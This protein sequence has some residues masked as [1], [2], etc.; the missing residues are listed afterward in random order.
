MPT[1]YFVATDKERRI[2]KGKLEA[3]D[4]NDAFARLEAAGFSQIDLE[5]DNLKDH[6]RAPTKSVNPYSIISLVAGLIGLSLLPILKPD[7]AG[8]VAGLVF[9]VLLCVAFVSAF[10]GFFNRH[11]YR[12]LS[13]LSTVML[14][15]SSLIIG[16][17]V[18][19]MIAGAWTRL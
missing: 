1:F 9:L 10:V 3:A 4:K 6:E 2:A 11:S 13:W 15:L 12:R 19:L 18:W 8:D 14:I 7:G 5:T 17:V 16:G